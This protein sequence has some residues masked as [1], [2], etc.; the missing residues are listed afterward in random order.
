MAR[1]ESASSKPDTTTVASVENPAE[2]QDQDPAGGGFPGVDYQI[3]EV[4]DLTIPA[5][6]DWSGV[7]WFASNIHEIGS[8]AV[9]PSSLVVL[10]AYIEVDAITDPDAI[11][12]R[13]QN[14]QSAWSSG[15]VSA[16]THKNGSGTAGQMVADFTSGG[17]ALDANDLVPVSVRIFTVGTTAED[18]HV[19]YA[20]ATVLAL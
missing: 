16:G 2:T 12:L 13:I 20:R 4:T 1:H 5:G 3:F 19:V 18:I 10:G 9:P 14:P 17:V 15:G 11:A 6:T 8:L 7:G